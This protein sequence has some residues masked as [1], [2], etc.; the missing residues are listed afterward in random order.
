MSVL[1]GQ[2]QKKACSARGVANV[3]QSSKC[4]PV[5]LEEVQLP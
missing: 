5:M 3:E 1:F 4:K 2:Q